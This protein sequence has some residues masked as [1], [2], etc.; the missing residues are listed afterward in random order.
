MRKG[1]AS[2]RQIHPDTTYLGKALILWKMWLWH[3]CLNLFV[4]YFPH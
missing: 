1:L 3:R 2:T 4:G